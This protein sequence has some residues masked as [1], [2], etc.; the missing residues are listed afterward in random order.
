MVS[1]PRL[2]PAQRAALEAWTA[3]PNTSQSWV[4]AN[5]RDWLLRHGFLTQVRTKGDVY[6]TT[7][8]GEDALRATG[9]PE[10]STVTGA[11]VR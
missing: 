10:F 11:P 3:E 9:W 5:T 4:R 2:S 6:A 1:G 7:S 8:A